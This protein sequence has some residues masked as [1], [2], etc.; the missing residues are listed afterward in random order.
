MKEE[1]V[2]A[3]KIWKE[4]TGSQNKVTDS[5]F[6]LRAVKYLAPINNKRFYCGW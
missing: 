4:E 1:R 2:E 5:R 3:G 6:V